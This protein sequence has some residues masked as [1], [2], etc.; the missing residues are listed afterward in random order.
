ML[1]VVMELKY[2]GFDWQSRQ[3]LVEKALSSNDAQQICDALY[4]AAQYESD[5]EWSQEQCLKFLNHKEEVRWAAALSF[6]F[7]ALYHRT[8]DLTKVLPALHAAKNDEQLAP[9][10]EDSLAMI[11]QYIKTN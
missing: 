1:L 2:K 10:I 8:L 3:D 7:I 6:G 5:W 4:S 9:H 11:R